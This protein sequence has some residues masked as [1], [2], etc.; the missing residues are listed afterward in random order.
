[1][2]SLVAG[3]NVTVAVSCTLPLA[4]VPEVCVK[5]LLTCPSYEAKNW[6]LPVIGGLLTFVLMTT[7]AVTAVP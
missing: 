4:S 3:L 7:V 5:E 2:V 1:M 6:M